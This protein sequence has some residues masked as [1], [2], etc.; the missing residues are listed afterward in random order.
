VFDVPKVMDPRLVVKTAGELEAVQIVLDCH[1]F[2]MSD[3][4][5]VA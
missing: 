4:A 2:L 1:L 3:M 5:L